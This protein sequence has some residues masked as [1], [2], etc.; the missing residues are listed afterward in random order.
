MAEDKSER[1][2]PA[3]FDPKTG[4]VHGSGSGAGGGGNPG[5][6][7]D[8]DSMAGSGAEPPHGPRTE[9]EAVDRPIDPDEGV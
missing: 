6:D 1:G 3:T 7:Y 4:E 8:Q 5:E 2:L 9:D